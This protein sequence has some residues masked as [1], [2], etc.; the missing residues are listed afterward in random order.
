MFPERLKKYIKTDPNTQKKLNYIAISNIIE[1]HLIKLN[2]ARPINILFDFFYKRSFPGSSTTK[3]QHLWRFRTLEFNK[4]LHI[5]KTIEQEFF[6][7]L[8]RNPSNSRRR[9][10]YDRI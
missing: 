1:R 7:S 8:C 5:N 2:S 9:I 3:K 10:K 4:R 6:I